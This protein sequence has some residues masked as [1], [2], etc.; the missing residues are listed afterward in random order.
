MQAIKAQYEKFG[1]EIENTKEKLR[2]ATDS[3]DKLEKRNDL[4]T[5][6]LKNIDAIDSGESDKLLGLDE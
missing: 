3:A 6:K 5:K 4:I 1:E 2:L